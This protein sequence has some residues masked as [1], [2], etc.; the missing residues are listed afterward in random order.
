MSGVFQDAI[1]S[2]LY[3]MGDLKKDQTV[4]DIMIIGTHYILI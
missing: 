4:S 3:P 1:A 2:L